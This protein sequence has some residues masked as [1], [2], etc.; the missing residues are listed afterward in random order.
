MPS[1]PAPYQEASYEAQF[2]G[3]LAWLFVCPQTDLDPSSGGASERQGEQMADRDDLLEELETYNVPT[4][5]I[6]R[7]KAERD[8]STLRKKLEDEIAWRKEHGEPA[9]QKV[10]YFETQPKRKETLASVGID[11]DSLPKYG[12]EVLDSLPTDKLDD[13]DY[14]AN[15]VQSKGFE[16]AQQQAPEP[17][18][19]PA[20]GVVAQAISGGQAGAPVDRDAL[21]RAAKSPEEVLELSRRYPPTPA[22]P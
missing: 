21:I 6:D 20:A 15:F 14:V 12:Q 3:A 11:Y 4:E 18:T 1:D 13:K 2:C 17:A 16:V 10:Q 8:S 22:T 7:L 9:V 19:E 5:V